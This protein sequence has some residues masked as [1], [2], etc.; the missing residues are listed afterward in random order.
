[1]FTCNFCKKNFVK[2]TSI[3]VHLCEPKRRHRE[4]DERGVQLGLQA[5]LKFYE[6]MQGSARLKTFTDFAESSYYQAFVKFGRYCVNTKVINP[7]R[8]LEWLLKQNKKIDQWCRDSMY[9]EYLLWYLTIESPEDA[10]ARA[11][12]F[13][14][15][16]AEA[17]QAQSHDCLRYGNPNALIHAIVSGKISAWVIYNSVSGQDFLNNLNAEQV[18]IIWPYINPEIWQK[19]FSDYFAD[20]EYAKEMLTQ[21]G[22]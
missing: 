18:A 12:E 19:K 8:F 5:Y 20:Q 7:S 11:I 13:S 6:T 22:W 14:L 21:A 10:L 16:W 17:N 4:Q 9:E 15:D 2:E 3:A 1:M